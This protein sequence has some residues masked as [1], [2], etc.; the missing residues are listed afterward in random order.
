MEKEVRLDIYALGEACDQFC[1]LP[2]ERARARDPFGQWL[3]SYR[4]HGLFD[5][6]LYVSRADG[7]YVSHGTA[8]IVNWIP[9]DGVY[10]GY[11]QARPGG[12][13]NY[14]YDVPMDAFLPGTRFQT[15]RADLER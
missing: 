1:N 12:T 8:T 4:R 6:R 14:R 13:L 3:S 5:L 10:H 15:Q 2:D 7:G 11:P 9:G